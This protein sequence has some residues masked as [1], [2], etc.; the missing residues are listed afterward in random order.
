MKMNF[1]SIILWASLLVPVQGQLPSF[2]KAPLLGT[3]AIHEHEGFTLK[4]NPDGLITI[5]PKMGP[6]G[7]ESAYYQIAQQLEFR[8][9][10][11]NGRTRRHLILPKS[12]TTKDEKSTKFSHA[13]IEGEA[14]GGI[15]FRYAITDKRGELTLQPEVL[16]MEEL[17]G[18]EI[19]MVI[20][21]R[22][23]GRYRDPDLLEGKAKKQTIENI[24]E[25]TVTFYPAKDS[26]NKKDSVTYAEV[27]NQEAAETINGE[28][29]FQK[30]I[31]QGYFQ[32]RKMCNFTLE[33]E[34]SNAT[35]LLEHLGRGND[36]PLYRA[37]AFQWLADVTDKPRQ[38]TLLRVELEED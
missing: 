12:L 3:F 24:D 7:K 35:L 26:K 22:M 27:L 36:V 25:T 17:T 10:M 13:T 29:G 33:S 30:I 20:Q 9:T 14:A 38:K 1:P 18:R 11:K 31:T 6:Q 37:H 16:N 32:H 23:G 8:E 5:H 28:E 21:T 19:K 15:K 34:G 4:I 2:D